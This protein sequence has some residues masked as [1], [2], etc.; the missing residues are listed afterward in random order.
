MLHDKPRG[1]LEP[2]DPGAVNGL[3]GLGLDRRVKLHDGLVAWHYLGQ[4]AG[5]EAVGRAD[6]GGRVD[7]VR[8]E[9][10]GH[11]GVC[12]RDIVGQKDLHRVVEAET[13][14]FIQFNKSTILVL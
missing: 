13:N 7:H 1:Q 2:A 12:V 14:G 11:G 5:F 3:N 10:E 6:D 8:V 4:E 9:G